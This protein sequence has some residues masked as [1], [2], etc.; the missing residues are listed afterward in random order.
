MILQHLLN[1][2]LGWDPDLWIGIKM[3]SRIRIC[4]TTMIIH[5]T[6]TKCLTMKKLT[7]GKWK[8][9]SC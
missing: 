1:Q 4:I 7:Y 5:N 6:V 8:S 9:K 2:G 3:K